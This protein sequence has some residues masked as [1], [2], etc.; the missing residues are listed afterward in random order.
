MQKLIIKKYG[1]FSDRVFEFA[2][3]TVFFGGNESGKTT[4]FDAIFEQ[5][6]SAAPKNS[7]VWRRLAMRYGEASER[8]ASADVSV[9]YDSGE[10]FLSLFSV[11]SSDISLEAGKDSWTETAGRNLFF[12]GLDV[13]KISS[14]LMKSANP[15]QNSNDAKEFK[16]LEACLR[17]AEA[18]LE[19]R[20]MQEK[21]AIGQK[22][23][24]EVLDKALASLEEEA[25]KLRA[26]REQQSEQIS[27][28]KKKRNLF[29]SV[30][31]RKMLSSYVAKLKLCDENPLVSPEGVQE[32]DKLVAA[33][34]EAKA[35]YDAAQAV[36][37]QKEQ[38]LEEVTKS[39][40]EQEKK[41][42]EAEMLEGASNTFKPEVEKIFE[43]RAKN[44]T[45]KETPFIFSLV[46]PVLAILGFA[47]A[48]IF[49]AK[50]MV[51]WLLF[52]AGIFLGWMF[53]S[54]YVRRRNRTA[55][56]EAEQAVI[57]KITH[58]WGERFD[59]KYIQGLSPEQ[60]IAKFDELIAS[61]KKERENHIAMLKD[62]EQS[63][64]AIT[65]AHTQSIGVQ[66]SYDTLKT[67]T[68]AWLADK[69]CK[70]RDSYL[71]L[72]EQKKAAMQAVM[73][74][75][76]KVEALMNEESCMTP[77]ALLAVI[78]SR[79]KSLPE[80]GFAAADWHK[81]E[82]SLSD[83]EAKADETSRL[84][85]E[86]EEEIRMA[87][88]DKVRNDSEFENSFSSIPDSIAALRKK[89]SGLKDE[90]KEIETRR[91]ASG[92]AAE[93]MAGMSSDAAAKFRELARK[94]AGIL[95]GIVP[96]AE[97]EIS[98]LSLSGIKMKD[99]GGTFR[100][101]SQLSSGTRDCLM[102]AMRLC[103]AADAFG[104]RDKIILLDD[105]FLNLDSARMEK[106]LTILRHFQNAY[107]CQL[108]FFTKEESLLRMLERDWRVK[109]H[110]LP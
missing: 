55:E 23:Q 107:G 45:F 108:V 59:T 38:H 20:L 89:I 49:H 47:A 56:K 63:Q 105:P 61:A 8:L 98:E 10:E 100:D 83:L 11:R 5:L 31:Q 64:M 41:R 53:H 3:V 54:S 96:G 60:M 27:E 78:D 6:C 75:K 67:S 92:L 48:W 88:V 85:H 70:D 94:A 66:I 29:R 4:V 28:L 42:K 91:Q 68:E 52:P 51:A 90:L 71:R 21:N 19:Q 13:Q 81:I 22:K 39:L 86:K 74:D 26:I 77:E 35:K 99:S 95:A 50:T 25:A 58:T 62:H 33:R 109:E 30:E 32:Y 15:R 12:Q 37:K 69:G 40:P 65:D 82:M 101:P 9:P 24:L 84:L 103:L 36:I 80:S 87:S 79:V 76:D 14:G 17:Q 102:L 72:V 73:A 34:D 18:E 43:Q 16:A 1:R 110:K 57:N 44:D 104:N 106:A 2:P 46:A 93:V 7:S 97:V